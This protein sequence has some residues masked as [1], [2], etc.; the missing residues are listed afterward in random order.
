MEYDEDATF[1]LFPVREQYMQNK[2]FKILAK[3][4]SK[5][6]GLSFLK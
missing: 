4:Q 3:N 6:V 2:V 1:M 5:H